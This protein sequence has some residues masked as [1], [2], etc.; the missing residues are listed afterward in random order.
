METKIC[1]GPCGEEKDISNFSVRYV[2]KAGINVYKT[3]CIICDKKRHKEYRDRGENKKKERE[4]YQTNKERIRKDQAEYYQLNKEV[5]KEKSKQ[6]RQDNK[7]E[8]KNGKKNYRQNNKE[9]VNAYKR[10][11]DRKRRREN[12]FVKLRGRLSG[13]INT[14]IKKNG[15]SKNGNSCLLH[16]DYPIT[17]LKEHL[18][19]QFEI[20]MTWENYGK[21]NAKTW[22]DND[23]STQTW[24]IDHIIPHSDLPYT[25]MEDDNFKKCWAL[26]NLRP[27][28]AKQ[29]LID[30]TNRIRHK[31]KGVK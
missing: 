6:Y 14:A 27:Y 25:S 29:N 22:D 8:V 2:N 7:E 9:K 19:N 26:E 12:P 11:Y 28:S 5:K 17:I 24:N 31:K 13:A 21:Y 3:N 23:P 10:E 1:K 16:I 20:W 18:E 30:G 4:Y 15:G